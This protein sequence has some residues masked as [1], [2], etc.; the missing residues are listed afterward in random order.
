MAL[1]TL[2]GT[3]RL[4]SDP[5]LR[6]SANGVAVCKVDL[7]FNDR[8]KNQQTGEWE[9]SGVLFVRGT[10]FKQLAEN[11]CESLAKGVEVA[12]TGRLKT[13]QWET[14][15]GEKR[16][17]TELL[18]DSI[19]PSLRTATATVQRMQRSGGTSGRPAAADA[20]TSSQGDDSAP[21]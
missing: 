17:A 3:G 1:P 9:D 21:F 18:I 7:A 4:T 5:E 16:S 15:E 11:I 19:G 13:E 2:T 10:A 8:R 12:V 20:W 6:F 14:R